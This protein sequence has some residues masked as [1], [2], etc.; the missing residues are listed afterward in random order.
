MQ[1]CFF[2][3]DNFRMMKA[4]Q[5][6]VSKLLSET[7]TLLCKNG[8]IYRDGIKIQGLLGVTLDKTDIF[9]VH[10]DETVCNVGAKDNTSDGVGKSRHLPTIPVVDLTT[11][12]DSPAIQAPMHGMG[13][14]VPGL[15]QPGAVGSRSGSGGIG[16]RKQRPMMPQMM[17]CNQH[18]SMQRFR[19]GTFPTNVH[20]MANSRM[21]HS[22]QLG[23]LAAMQQMQQRLPLPQLHAAPSR[24]QQMQL[25]VTVALDDD[26][27]VVIIG[28][29]HEE[30]SPNWNSSV[31]RNHQGQ[32]D[33]RQLGS[34]NQA[35]SVKSISLK[36]AVAVSDVE[37][38]E[39]NIATVSLIGLPT[40]SIDQPQLI[41]IMNE[42][43]VEDL[44][45][46]M[47]MEPVVNSA[48]LI[49]SNDHD[50][51]IDNLNSGGDSVIGDKFLNEKLL[52]ETDAADDDCS[53][54][55]NN[56]SELEID[57]N[58][59][60]DTLNKATTLS[61]ENSD[62]TDEDDS[63]ITS[64]NTMIPLTE[65]ERLSGTNQQMPLPTVYTDIADGQESVQVPVW[66]F[67]II[68]IG[69]NRSKDLSVCNM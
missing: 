47:D 14:V 5:E 32:T 62:K 49:E 33:S 3:L 66:A 17:S 24:H 21:M 57:S 35:K 18:I 45:E 39:P 59:Y 51:N 55:E 30:P 19:G 42:R 69:R 11:V 9:I 38:A 60:Q 44:M 54:N 27:D 1:L 8:L 64:H 58:V 22:R 23:N 56:S 63:V 2:S 15:S 43:R 16:A 13:P 46:T 26:E 34:T 37:P 48:M 52:I 68:G 29:G 25:P 67:I 31:R 6:R 28:T 36:E 10:I 53:T 65:R 41:S 4:D 61:S 20:V 7:V 40:E 50:L 12:A